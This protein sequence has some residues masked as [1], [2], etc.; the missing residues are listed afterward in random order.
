[1]RV[2]IV[3][4]Q[5]YISA[6]TSDWKVLRYRDQLLLESVILAPSIVLPVAVA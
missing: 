6:F 4:H 2:G 1:M 5:K 3:F